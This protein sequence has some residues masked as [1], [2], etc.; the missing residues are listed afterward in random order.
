MC[1]K[2]VFHNDDWYVYDVMAEQTSCLYS[3]TLLHNQL[4]LPQTRFHKTNNW[5]KIYVMICNVKCFLKQWRKYYIEETFRTYECQRFIGSGE[6]SHNVILRSQAY[7]LTLKT[8]AEIKIG[9][10]RVLSLTLHG[11]DHYLQDDASLLFRFIIS[12]Y[13]FLILVL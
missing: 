8:E 1:R 7:L 5:N 4:L 6:I 2:L 13:S 10:W 11:L 3:K 12:S 9:P